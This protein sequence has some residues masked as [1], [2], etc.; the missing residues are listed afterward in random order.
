M[1][2]SQGSIDL[3]N[4]KDW[5]SRIR[6]NIYLHSSDCEIFTGIKGDSTDLFYAVEGKGKGRWGLK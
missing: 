1:I 5:K 4:Y 3:T 2:E 6:T